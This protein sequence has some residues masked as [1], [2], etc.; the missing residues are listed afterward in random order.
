MSLSNRIIDQLDINGFD[1]LYLEK[2]NDM[3][4]VELSQ[5]TPA[6]EDW[7]PTIWFDGTESGFIKSFSSYASEFDIDEEV[8]FWIPIRGTRGVPNSSSVLIEDTEWKKRK[9]EECAIA[10]EELL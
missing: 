1:V 9:L 4:C 3:F 2:N 5:F 7:I 10:L 6:G 8:E